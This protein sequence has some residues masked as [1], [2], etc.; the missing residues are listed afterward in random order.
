MAA[1]VIYA[2]DESSKTYRL[3]KESTTIGRHPESDILLVSGSASGRHAVI[4]QAEDGSFYVND[5]GSSNGTRVNGAE[6]EEAL[7]KDGDRVSF[8]DE[9]G[10]FYVGE[11]PVAEAKAR[12]AVP[13]ADKVVVALPVPATLPSDR[14]MDGPRP[15]L[16]P[17]RRAYSKNSTPS[18]YPD[19]T[20]GG[21]MTA[22]IVIGLF[23]TAFIVGL[24]LR[25]HKE[26]NGNF[27]NDFIG[28]MTEKLPSIE[29]KEKDKEDKK[30]GEAEKDGGES[31]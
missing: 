17:V 12:P 16:S 21:C 13:A 9:Q 11:P 10:V 28:K 25:H 7:L 4:K 20:G 2:E 3:D 26:M 1:I 22:A 15:R 18:D 5:L 24:S 8:G 27:L 30:S 6:I 14:A 23:F 31:K 19:D 29:L